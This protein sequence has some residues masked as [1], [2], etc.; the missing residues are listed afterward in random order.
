[1]TTAISEAIRKF[2]ISADFAFDLI[3]Q[4]ENCKSKAKQKKFNTRAIFILEQIKFRYFHLKSISSENP[5]VEETYRKLENK[6]DLFD[7][8]IDLHKLPTV[9]EVFSPYMMQ[10]FNCIKD[11]EKRLEVV[12]TFI[13][14]L[15]DMRNAG[16]LNLDNPTELDFQ[17]DRFVKK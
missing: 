3:E 5:E 14:D 9:A 15:D 7:F 17:Y 11:K 4:I 16:N 1:M 10:S 13:R 8:K 2:N 12:A 6:L